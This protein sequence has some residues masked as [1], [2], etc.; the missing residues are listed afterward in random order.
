MF[1]RA[2]IAPPKMKL[3]TRNDSEL[4]RKSILFCLPKAAKVM[5]IPS[6]I[7]ISTHRTGFKSGT[8]ISSEP[9]AP[10]AEAKITRRGETL[11]RSMS[12]VPRTRK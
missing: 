9:T 5:P 12:E 6:A 3:T 10:T 4:I 8:R 7:L 2:V 1:H 11:R